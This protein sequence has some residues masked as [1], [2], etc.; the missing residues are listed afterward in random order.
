LNGSSL[1]QG[2]ET[3]QV[4][5]LAADAA[6][7]VYIGG[8]DSYTSAEGF[9]TTPGALQPA[10]LVGGNSG[11]CGTGFVTKLSSSGSLL[12][13]TFYGSPSATGGSGVAAIALDSANDV[14]IAANNGGLGDYPLNNGFQSFAGGG[15]Y[16]TE[17]SGNGSQVLFGSYYG[18]NAATYP[19]GLLVDASGNIF[20]AGYTNAFLPLIN[21]LQSTN[22]GGGFPE[23]FFAKIGTPV[24]AVTLVANA[25]GESL[26]IAPNTWVE[27]KGSNLAP[28]KRSWQTSDFVNGQMPTQLD[29]VGVTM[30]GKNTYIYYISPA[31]VNVL[32]PPDL[33]VGPVQVKVTFNGATAAAFTAQAQAASPSFFVLN[34]G[35][36]IVA[37]HLSS[38][39]CTAPISGVCLVGPA[40]LY[41]GYSTPAQPNETIVIYA[42]GFGATTTQVV[43]GAET[44]SGSLPTLPMIQI[45]NAIVTATFAGLISPGLYQFNVAVPSTL[46]NGDQSITASYNGQTTQA[47]TLITIHN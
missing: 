35:P 45:G 30:N 9:P 13:S 6:G 36:Y 11:E 28:D 25:E 10:C 29:G 47:G 46:A 8:Y 32:A 21:P 1:T 33:A 24:V 22:Y 41:P 2:N 12:W 19:T 43:S 14:Y 15:A 7:N 26:T 27:I 39:A 3:S 42:N 37:A 34:G 31:Q 4:N 5:A 17:L 44:Q 38:S 20:V 23:G 18:G 16:I 40:T